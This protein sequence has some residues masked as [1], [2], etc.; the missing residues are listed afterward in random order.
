LSSELA[1]PNFSQ[2]LK[3]YFEDVNKQGS[4]AGKACARAH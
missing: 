2:R 3:Q 1:P 4:E